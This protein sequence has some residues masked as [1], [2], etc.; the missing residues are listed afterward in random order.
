MMRVTP[1]R[2]TTLQCSQIGLTLLRTFT[3]RLQKPDE[4]RQEPSETTR[5]HTEG[6]EAPRFGVVSQPNPREGLTQAPVLTCT[7]TMLDAEE[8]CGIRKSSSGGI[9]NGLQTT[10]DYL[11][12]SIALTEF[13]IRASRSPRVLHG[14][15]SRP[16]PLGSFP[17][18]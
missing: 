6:V 14:V 17:N 16:D 13:P 5:K 18:A 3:K 7:D 4:N 1:R 11:P 9:R 12:A 15:R 8:E 2:L 10:T